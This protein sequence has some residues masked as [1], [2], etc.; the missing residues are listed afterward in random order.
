MSEENRQPQV[1]KVTVDSEQMKRL[2]E[3]NRQL[4]EEKKQMQ[5]TIA[6]S[7]ESRKLMDDLKEKAAVEL[8]ALGV[9]TETTDIKTKADLDRCISTIQQ[10]RRAKENVGNNP[11]GNAGLEGQ[12]GQQNN[13]GFSN[14]EQLIDTV[15]DKASASNKDLA[16]RAEAQKVLDALMVKALRGQGESHKEFS[17]SPSEGDKGT[18]QILHDKAK[19]RRELARGEN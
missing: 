17:Y 19:R 10:L 5:T 16:S 3:Q 9:P 18:L 13:Q 7:E 1:V 8:E 15:R 6:E 12:Y 14:M 2:I 11:S 4:E